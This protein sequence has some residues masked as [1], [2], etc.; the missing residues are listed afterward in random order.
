MEKLTKEKI[1]RAVADALSRGMDLKITG[2]VSSNGNTSD[3]T[4][5]LHGPGYYKECVAAALKMAEDPDVRFG[6]LLDSPEVLE[7][8][9]AALRESWR[10]TLAGEHA[11][12]NFKEELDTE[13]LAKSG[14]AA[15]AHGNVVIRNLEMRKQAYLGGPP[16]PKTQSKNPV[17][18]A[19]GLI[20]GQ[21]PLGKY[22][23]QLNLHPDRLEG[24]EAVPA[25]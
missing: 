17:V 12:R 2:Y 16:A 4:V 7:E 19:K 9:L 25:E 15:D 14:F 1:E 6:R 5:R 22:V 3:M 18:Q 13:S 21:T 20:T 11:A 10:K 24:I 23:G 8:A